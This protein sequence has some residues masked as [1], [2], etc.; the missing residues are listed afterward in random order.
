MQHQKIYLTRSV[1]I[2]NVLLNQKQSLSAFL[3]VERKDTQNSASIWLERVELFIQ[4]REQIGLNIEA[5]RLV[6]CRGKLNQSPFIY[7][8]HLG[9]LIYTN[10]MI[11]K[12][13]Y[14]LHVSSFGNSLP[15]GITE[16]KSLARLKTRFSIYTDSKNIQMCNS[17]D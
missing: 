1:L 13:K 4:R 16:A 14:I 7:I 15:W 11:A 6:R 5:G 12:R 9:K 2:P 3:S 17:K 10:I 8:R